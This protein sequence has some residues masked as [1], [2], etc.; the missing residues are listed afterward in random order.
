MNKVLP[1]L[2]S[3]LKF[4]YYY[5]NIILFNS[6]RVYC[7]KFYKN[8]IMLSKTIN[9]NFFINKFWIL[10]NKQNWYFLGLNGLLFTFKSKPFFFKYIQN[11]YSFDKCNSIFNNFIGSSSSEKNSKNL[12]KY[13]YVNVLLNFFDWSVFFKK[14]INKTKFLFIFAATHPI[15]NIS[16]KYFKKY[17]FDEYNDNEINFN[18]DLSENSDINFN[19]K[20]LLSEFFFF[21][22]KVEYDLDID[23]SFFLFFLIKSRSCSNLFKYNNYMLNFNIF[24]NFYYLIYYPYYFEDNMFF[25]NIDFNNRNDI[26]LFFDKFIYPIENSVEVKDFNF[27]YTFFKIKLVICEDYIL[28]TNLFNLLYLYGFTKKKT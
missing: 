3:S 24:L 26:T 27:N 13:K 15:Q 20:F 2:F 16:F 7:N 19:K 11:Y 14:N 5:Y 4:Y 28:F 23:N 12:W 18:L 8:T 10:N 6:K 1:V 9:L 25:Y 17:E 21:N 22:N